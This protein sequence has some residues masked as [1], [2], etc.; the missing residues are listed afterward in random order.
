MTQMNADTKATEPATYMIVRG[1]SG[2]AGLGVRKYLETAQ[3][4]MS[5]VNF[6]DVAGKLSASGVDCGEVQSAL[7][8]MGILLHAFDEAAAV[9]TAALRPLTD[10]YG[11]SLGD[12]ACLSLAKR[13]H[14]PAVTAD[15][16]WS[17]LQTPEIK[18]TQI[19]V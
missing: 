18:V 12:R 19:R 8:G 7:H 11:L 6:C 9:E 5:T 13:L 3:V 10:Q 14:A 17:F 16:Q 15:K 1:V 2:S 4:S